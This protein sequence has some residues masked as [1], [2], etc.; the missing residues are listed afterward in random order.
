MTQDRHKVYISVYLALIKDDKVLLH[1]RQNSNYANGFYSLVSGHAEAGESATNAMIREAEE[2]VGIKIS[3]S[4]LKF[5]HVMHIKTDRE[6]VSIFYICKN[7]QGK[8]TNC[9]PEKCAELKFFYIDD[10]PENTVPQ[11]KQF[12]EDLETEKYYTESGW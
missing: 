12:L 2:E 10:I 9:E 11:V 8:I 1:L 4:D 5:S 6:D 3:P 7:W